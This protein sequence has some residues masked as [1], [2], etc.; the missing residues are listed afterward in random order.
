MDQP[1]VVQ[2]QME[3]LALKGAEIGAVHQS[4]N[5]K[6]KQNQLVGQLGGHAEEINL[7]INYLHPKINSNFLSLKIH[8]LQP[9]ES[10]RVHRLNG[11]TAQ[12]QK[13]DIRL[14]SK[15]VLSNCT[16]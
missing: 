1:I 12:I 11:I 14:R 3:Q 13:L 4:E 5:N 15:S 8:Y 10:V 9:A 6:I 16:N 7:V 2:G